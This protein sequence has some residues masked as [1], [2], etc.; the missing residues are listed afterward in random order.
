MWQLF[1]TKLL[2]HKHLKNVHKGKT[3]ILLIELKK[4]E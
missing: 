1:E 3:K 2:K 4:N